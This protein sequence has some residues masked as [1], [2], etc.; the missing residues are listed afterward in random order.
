MSVRLAPISGIIIGIL[1]IAFRKPVSQCVESCYRRFPKYEDGV[2]ALNIKFSIRP[3]Y[4][5]VFGLVI[6]M[7][8]LIGLLTSL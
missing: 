4:I 8:S 5:T 6:A 1:L 2:K 7:F 3:V